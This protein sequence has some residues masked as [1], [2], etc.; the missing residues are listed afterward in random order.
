MRST[1]RGRQTPTVSPRGLDERVDVH[2]QRKWGDALKGF[3][4]LEGLHD[5][6]HDGLDRNTRIRR[7][8]ALG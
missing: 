8:G 3:G 7:D 1:V 6:R 2:S 4:D 5:S